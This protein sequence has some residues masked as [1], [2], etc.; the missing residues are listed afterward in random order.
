MVHQA[1]LFV[2]DMIMGL[3]ECAKGYFE[4]SGALYFESGTVFNGKEEGY[5]N[6]SCH[7]VDI[8]FNNHMVRFSY[9]S[10]AFMT[11]Y[12]SILTCL[13]SFEKADKE[14]RV[15]YPLYQLYGY[16]GQ[17]PLEAMV[18]PLILDGE[19]LKESFGQLEAALGRVHEKIRELSFDGEGRAAFFD[20]EVQA[21]AVLLKEDY[22]TNEEYEGLWAEAR[23]QW[24][25]SWKKE[26]EKDFD[27]SELS[28]EE[29]KAQY[30][31]FIER[32]KGQ[33]TEKI[34]IDKRQMLSLYYNWLTSRVL[35][36]G[37]EAYMVGDYPRALQKLRK[38]KNKTA[39]DEMVIAY[40]ERAGEGRPH[41]PPSV[42]ENIK[43]FYKNGMR[44]STIG[45]GFKVVAGGYLFG[46]LWLP[47][48]L[49]LYFLFYF[50]ESRGAVYFMGNPYAG[51]SAIMPCFLLGMLTVFFRPGMYYKIFYRKDYDKL[52]AVEKASFNPATHKF[53]KGLAAIVFLGCLVYL[54]FEAHRNLKLTEDGI[55]DNTRFWGIKGSFYTYDEVEK[56][57]RIKGDEAK[58]Y[59]SP[60]VLRLKGGR[61]IELYEFGAGEKFF[62]VLRD[63][64][65]LVEKGD[66]SPAE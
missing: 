54:F 5:E 53:M 40:L 52:M 57:Y 28:E 50:I 22:P 30:E 9:M 31:W 19:T 48:F 58:G 20:G 39:Y 1:G 11:S 8:Y 15:F 13:V 41:V 18:I 3:E 21:A 56:V 25:E 35:S 66:G 47:L 6:I 38:L 34:D 63:K 2:R 17:G 16:F 59:V 55:L 64:G 32:I 62:E 12:N 65:V 7:N 27:L 49:G 36:A 46:L 26:Q 4:R 33:V 23:V 29:L 37:Y 60:Y 42:C 61:E 10:G 43:K 14:K 24:F 51:L 44:K 45:E